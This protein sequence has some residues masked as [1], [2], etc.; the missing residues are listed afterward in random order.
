VLIITR[1]YVRDGTFAA[2]AVSLI[3]RSR[4]VAILA[5]L[6]VAIAASRYR[7]PTL[8]DS[9]DGRLQF[10]ELPVPAAL[11]LRLNG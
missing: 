10:E 1:I 8:A 9:N 7:N 11:E 5:V 6:I 4:Y 2:S 3:D